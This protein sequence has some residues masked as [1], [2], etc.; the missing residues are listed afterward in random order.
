MNLR[1]IEIVRAVMRRR[2][3]V[4]AAEELA[5]S[6]SAVS[7]AI[8]HAESSLGFNLFERINNRLVPTE[9]AKLMLEKAEPL[10]MYQ[11]AVNRC[12]EDLKAGRIGR[13]RVV[14]TS[15]ISESILPHAISAFLETHQ[16]VTFE[17]DSRP[18]M[19]VLD[20]IE[21]GIGDIGFVLE[22]P[23]RHDLV[24]EE[25]AAVSAVCA[26]RS[27][28]PLASHG[29][30][31]PEDIAGE[32][33]VAPALHSIVGILFAEAFARRSVS[34]SPHVQVRFMNV[35]ARLAQ[36][37]CGVALIDEITVA[38]GHF[39]DL[40]AIP[41]SP[42]IT[43]ALTVVLPRNRMPSRLTKDFKA[44]FQQT[45]NLRL[46]AARARQSTH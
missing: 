20:E 12:A 14:A 39:S 19:S 28:H 34:Y 13:I 9:E 37:G 17:L 2:T 8:K 43:L 29:R 41:F 33:L 15:E 1:Q 11:Q 40:V 25:I 32:R 7:N 44:C 45:M 22:A 6:Q 10:F 18:L 24:L 4:A 46:G 16:A 3:T 42:A 5:M 38:S 35:A 26:C 27:D 36:K 30:V 21:T 23:K 31:D